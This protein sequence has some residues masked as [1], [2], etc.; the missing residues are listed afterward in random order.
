M[1]RSPEKEKGREEEVRRKQIESTLNELHRLQAEIYDLNIPDNPHSSAPVK[2]EVKQLTYLYENMISTHPPSQSP[3]PKTTST[4]PRRTS[5]R[6]S[7][8][9]TGP[10][11]GKGPPLSIPKSYLL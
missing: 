9:S 7:T 2:K 11:T 3:R 6:L 8:L 4:S 1:K 5:R 10:R